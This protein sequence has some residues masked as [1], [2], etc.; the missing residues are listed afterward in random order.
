MTAPYAPECEI[1]NKTQIRAEACRAG[2]RG[3]GGRADMT[4]M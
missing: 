3:G 4:R 2:G 1:A